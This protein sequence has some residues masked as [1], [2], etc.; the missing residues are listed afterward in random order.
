M[1]LGIDHIGVAVADPAQAATFLDALQMTRADSGPAE[2]YGV[3]CQFWRYPEQPAMPAIEIVSPTRDESAI[4]GR[5]TRHGPGL[6]HVA[7]AVQGIEAEMDRLRAAGFT[8]VDSAPRRGARTGMRV[9]FMYAR[10]PLGLLIEL[11]EYGAA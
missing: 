5:L 8:A 11:V 2:D 10:R 3:A 6:Y 7:F 4:A 9:A 1:I